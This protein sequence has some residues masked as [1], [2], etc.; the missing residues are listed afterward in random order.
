VPGEG[1]EDIVEGGPPH[2]HVVDPDPGLVEPA[3]G[4]GDRPLAL[5]DRHPQH[6][7]DQGRALRRDRLQRRDR[8]LGV[9]LDFKRDVEPLA[10]DLVP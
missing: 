7:L 9:G 6:A 1:E 4:V 2:R 10:A 5:L 8:R 3:H